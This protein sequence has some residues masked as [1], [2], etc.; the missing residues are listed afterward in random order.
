MFKIRKTYYSKKK[1]IHGLYITGN[2]YGKYSVVEDMSPDR[3]PFTRK[4]VH[5]GSLSSCRS[6][7]KGRFG[8]K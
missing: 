2:F 4:I 3:N 8:R 1:G 7:L 6:Y 5:S